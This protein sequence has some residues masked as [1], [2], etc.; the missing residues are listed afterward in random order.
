MR[1]TKNTMRRTL[2][3]TVPDDD[4]KDCTDFPMV[5]LSPT[6]ELT[7]TLTPFTPQDQETAVSF[8]RRPLSRPLSEHI[9]TPELDDVS[10]LRS[11]SWCP[12]YSALESPAPTLKK[13][14]SI[15]SP[16]KWYSDSDESMARKR[17]F[18]ESNISDHDIRRIL[19]DLGQSQWTEGGSFSECVDALLAISWT[20]SRERIESDERSRAKPIEHEEPSVIELV[21]GDLRYLKT[22][23]SHKLQGWLRQNYP[24]IGSDLTRLRLVKMVW[25]LFNMT[26]PAA[27]TMTKRLCPRTT[28]PRKFKCKT[29]GVGKRNRAERKVV[30]EDKE[31]IKNN[32]SMDDNE[33]V[34]LKINM[35][36]EMD[37][38]GDEDEPD[39]VM[40]PPM[41]WDTTLQLQFC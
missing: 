32:E 13:C 14:V 18:I 1:R 24:A 34:I 6:P 5:T 19:H 29:P 25:K 31:V 35:K 17:T 10:I 27:P 30:V 33:A 40:C 23:P 2:R 12:S 26:S 28:K 21:S 38:D 15:V 37:E 36:L 39:D 22:V 16:V 20:P 4:E 9:P 7:P 8:L 11:S 3:C 41:N